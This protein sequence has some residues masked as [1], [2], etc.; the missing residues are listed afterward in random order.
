MP[1]LLAHAIEDSTDI[2]GISGGGFEHPKPPPLGT[3][4]T[5][6]RK[7]GIGTS[8]SP[9]TSAFLCQLSPHKCSF[10]FMAPNTPVCQGLLLV[11]DS[12]SHSDTPQ[13]VCLL[14]TSDQPDAEAST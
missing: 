14:W 9:T 5:G 6:G 7:T 4:L 11:E 12:R 2:F 3:P 8:F 10:S 1:V 13:S